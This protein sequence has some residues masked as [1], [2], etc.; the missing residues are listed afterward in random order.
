MLC[1][2]LILPKAVYVKKTKMEMCFGWE[3]P[4]S[5]IQRALKG[6]YGTAGILGASFENQ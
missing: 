5:S 1:V 2:S 4:D 6:L 3:F